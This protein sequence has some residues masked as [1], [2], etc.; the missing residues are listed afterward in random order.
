M[1]ISEEQTAF[2]VKTRTARI[3]Y[4]NSVKIMGIHLFSKM[5]N[6]ISNIFTFRIRWKIVVSSE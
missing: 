2:Q 3:P 5:G 1:A 4:Q 6:K